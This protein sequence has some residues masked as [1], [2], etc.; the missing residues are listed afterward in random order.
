MFVKRLSL[1]A[2]ALAVVSAVPAQ[3]RTVP[4]FT[5]TDTAGKQVSLADFKDRKAVAVIFVGTECP[6]VNLYLPRLAELQRDLGPRGLQV[7]AVNS[8]SQDAPEAAARHARE[9]KLP[10]PVLLDP[11]QKVADLF[12]AT[13]TPEAFLLD[14]AGTVV[15]RGRI[16]DRYTVGGDRGAPTRHDLREAIDEVLAGKPVSVARTPVAGCFIGRARPAEPRTDV[17]Y[18]KHIAPIMQKYCQECHRPGQV[19]PFSLMTYKQARSWA[20]TIREV[21]LDNRMPPWHADPR[22]GSFANDRSLTKQDRE[23]LLAWID[24]DCPKGDD[25]DMPP[26][27]QWPQGWQIGTPDLVLTM[28]EPF[29]VPAEAPKGGIPYQRFTLEASFPEDVWVQA[30]EARPGNRAVVHHML[31]FIGDPPA[32]T[33]EVVGDRKV[34]VG[35][36]P[37]SRPAVYPEGLGLRIPA[38]SKLVLEMHYTANGTEQLDRS[39][40]AVVFAKAPPKHEVRTRFVNN[41]DFVIPPRAANHRAT[42][43]T[44]FA[45]DSVLLAL[46]PHMH[47]RGKSFTFRVVYPDGRTEVL[48]SVPRYDFNWQHIYALK[49]PLRLPAGTRIECEARYDNSASNPNNPDPSSAVRW[50]DQSWEEMLVGLLWY[51]HA[52][53]PQRP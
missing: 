6:L 53:G 30:V 36:V 51:Y 45:K 26:P 34:L 38:G 14:A 25:R 15:Y 19:G 18:A 17:T 23:L 3:A 5:L 32:T 49:A 2:L 27:R 35:Y 47:V 39:Q 7:L 8:N 12:G 42:A 31:V 20:E 9:R 46:S 48:L 4:G 43:S 52:D 1:T 22:H 11:N 21:V 44:T 16:D 33:A 40:V 24:N 50:G 37:G 28:K 41:R 10:F 29:K 13:R